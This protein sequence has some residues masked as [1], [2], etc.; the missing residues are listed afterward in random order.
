MSKPELKE[1]E[2]SL[3][4]MEDVRITARDGLEL[5]GYL[6]RTPLQPKDGK[7][8][9]ILLVHG[10]PWARDYWGFNAQSQ[11]FA[12]RGYSTLQVNFRASTGYG[13]SFLHKGDKQWGEDMQHDLTD[14]V[15]WAIEEG[16]ADPDKVCIYG[17]SYGGYACLGKINSWLI[18]PFVH[19][20]VH[21][22]IAHCLYGTK[23]CT[24]PS[25]TRYISLCSY[26][27]FR[28]WPNLYTRPVQMRSGYCWAQQRQD[29]TRLYPRLLGAPSQCHAFEDWRC[30]RR[31]RVQSQ[32][33]ATF[34]RRQ[35]HSPPFDRARSK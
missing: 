17:G 13:K 12:N 10:G 24:L 4:L 16:I 2:D 7:A 5:V 9:L 20:F 26:Q 23:A 19:S 22:S 11:W 29:A 6:T 15:H 1:Y 35:N 33:I 28:S 30:R 32:N 25:H 27:S 31:R 18:H 8:P 34:P 21:L 14:A 3:A